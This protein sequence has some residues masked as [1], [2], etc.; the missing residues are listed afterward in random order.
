MN[1][2]AKNTCLM[3]VQSLYLKES[4]KKCITKKW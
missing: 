1:L 4:K 3:N 2:Y